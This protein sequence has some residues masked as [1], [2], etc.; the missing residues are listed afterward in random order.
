MSQ[1]RVPQVIEAFA[2]GE[3]V[4]VTDDDDRE[5]EGDLILA[6][7]HATPEKMAFI[8]RHT[9]GIVCAPLTGGN[10]AA[11]ASCADGRGQRRNS[12]HRFYGF[13]RLPSRHDNRDL[14][15]RPHGDDPQPREQQCGAVGFRPAGPYLP[16]DRKGWRRADALGSHR[17]G[18]RPVPAR[19]HRAGGGDLRTGQRRR[20]RDARPASPELRQKPWPEANIG[21][22]SDRLSPGTREARDP[23]GRIHRGERDRRTRRLRVCDAVRQSPPLRVRLRKHRRRQQYPDAAPPG[24][25]PRR[26]VRRRQTH[27]CRAEPVQCRRTGGPRLSAGRHVGSAGLSGR[28][29]GAP[30]RSRSAMSSGAR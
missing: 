29:G 16:V 6:A 2:R 5:N 4:V 12:R 27:P 7:V 23:G 20:H 8:I 21:S 11:P 30:A 3:I 9:C 28:R 18:D 22:R 24:Q 25:R 14:R 10:R 26:R 17:S 19:R 13:G 15:R 1:S